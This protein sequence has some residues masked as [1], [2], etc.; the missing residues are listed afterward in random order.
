MGS[1]LDIRYRMEKR[2]DA[3]F[4]SDIDAQGN[5]FN[6]NK[7]LS[8]PY[9]KELSHDNLTPQ[10]NDGTIYASGQSYRNIDSAYKHQKVYYLKARLNLLV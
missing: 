2:H 3:G 4:I 6:P 8:D 5:R 10:W 7:L 9:A 1:E